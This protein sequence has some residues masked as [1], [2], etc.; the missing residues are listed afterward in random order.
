MLRLMRFRVTNFRSV[1]DSGWIDFDDV[2]AFIGEN[3][4]GKTNLLVP[5]W[6][7]N[8]AGGGAI[9]LIADYPRGD[10]GEF[11]DLN[12]Q[13]VFIEALLELDDELTSR[14][15]RLASMAPG[16]VRVVSVS[17]RFDGNRII[18]FPNSNP[19]R[20]LPAAELSV[21]LQNVRSELRP[22][23][24]STTEETI[25][26]EMLAVIDEVLVQIDDGKGTIT[27]DDLER[28][29]RQLEAVDTEKTVKRSTI[30][31]RYGQLLDDI[32]PLIARV[33]TPV[34]EKIPEVCQIVEPQ[35]PK[36]VYYSNYGNLDSEIYLPHVI[37]NMKRHDLGAKEL[38]NA[39]T[40]KV[41]FDF[42]NLEP[43]EIL[44]LGQDI[45]AD[46]TEPT[47]EEIEETAK[48]KKEREILLT[49]AS[50]RLT[51]EFHAWWKQGDY[52]F[53]FNADGN[54]FRIW[55]KDSIRP[56]EIE[57]ESRSTGLQWFLSFFLTFL[58]ESEDAHAG[59]IL[60]LDEPGHSLHPTAQEVLSAFFDNLAATNQIA[61][62]T[63]SPHLVDPDHLDRARAV[64]IDDRGKTAVS[65][66]LRASERNPSQ[67]RAVHA[68][69]AA[70]GLTVSE[71]LL[72]GCQPVIVE[73]KSDQIYLGAM[74]NF[75]IGQGRITPQRELIF[76]PAGGVRGVTPLVS[77]LT[78][79]DDELPFVV[80]DADRQ[81]DD[82]AKKLMSGLYQGE[83]ERI[84]RVSDI[85]GLTGAEMEDLF[86][87]SFLAQVVGREYRGKDYFEDVVK[88]GGLI[89]PQIEAYATAEGIGLPLG[90]KVDIAKKVKSRLLRNPIEI[91]GNVAT[92][93]HWKA[94]FVRLQGS[95]T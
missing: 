4:S 33:S 37:D 52:V 85:C 15:A 60:L 28:V 77:I 62:T 93:E 32:E 58:V 1:E 88:H 75:L 24:T 94:L 57:L 42:V 12:P 19:V 87:S 17:R 63:H 9:D 53:R 54:H 2:L 25:K 81:G 79:T 39:R 90:W 92:V 6:K 11:K 65:T 56:D 10:Y 18:M 14:V 35:L 30:G 55:V 22:L 83:Q 26:I 5:L 43:D 76:V 7:L 73:G 84:I 91:A 34:P 51:R 20:E 3:E 49:S 47:Q 41:L 16:D 70:V 40:L 61:Y 45:Y 31:P 74:K 71:T 36:F 44:E 38:A 78:A 67:T 80:L 50:G 8:P 29:K 48:N 69:H 89:V 21:L 72:Y 82:M 59:S 46:T 66:D 86:P 68:V 95:S 23:S 64:Y 13:P 27:S